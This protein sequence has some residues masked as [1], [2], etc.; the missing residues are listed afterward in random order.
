[1]EQYKFDLKP[2]NCQPSGNADFS[3][4]YNTKNTKHTKKQEKLIIIMKN[5]THNIAFFCDKK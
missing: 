4:I 3:K 1:M 5:G 2:E